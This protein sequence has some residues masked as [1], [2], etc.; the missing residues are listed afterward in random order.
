MHST[1]PDPSPRMKRGNSVLFKDQLERLPGHTALV[2]HT[3]LET[4]S[5]QGPIQLNLYLYSRALT[6]YI[7]GAQYSCY[8]PIGNSSKQKHRHKLKGNELST[9]LCRSPR[10]V[11]VSACISLTRWLSNKTAESA[12][13][14]LYTTWRSALQV[15]KDKWQMSLKD[16]SKWK[17]G[18]APE[19]FLRQWC[20]KHSLSWQNA[21]SVK[22]A[23]QTD[24]CKIQNFRSYEND[25]P[26]HK[27]NGNQISKVT[28]WCEQLTKSKL[29]AALSVQTNCGDIVIFYLSSRSLY[30]SRKRRYSVHRVGI[31][32]FY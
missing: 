29:I 6:T 26:K 2:F 16:M 3:R 1:L 27:K 31:I 8:L 14:I 4:N 20:G 21:L 11:W 28:H 9:A 18:S 12:Q 13:W 32:S 5:V 19:F 25:W 10:W 24:G 17:T 22:S 15:W 23:L 30:R 7:N